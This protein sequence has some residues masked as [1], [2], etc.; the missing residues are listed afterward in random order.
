MK[1]KEMLKEFSQIM[2]LV[3]KVGEVRAYLIQ[4]PGD[5]PLDIKKSIFKDF[6]PVA[7]LAFNQAYSADFERDVWEHLF[8]PTGL[9]LV[10]NEIAIHDECGNDED[11][12]VAFRTFSVIRKDVIYL[13][14]V[15]IHPCFHKMGLYH[16]LIT[17]VTSDFDFVVTRTQSPL[18]IT[19]L[20]NVFGK[21]S[22]I[23][24]CA[25][26][27]EKEVA[28]LLADN[29]KMLDKFDGEC[30][31]GWRTYGH[32]L[33]RI[34]PKADENITS[35]LYSMIDVEAGDCVIAVCRTR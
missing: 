12:G 24:K 35:M 20:N 21:I 1:T 26:D 32:S 13:A 2:L 18:V 17:C 6:Y 29:L 4:N 8:S 25:D 5:L 3:T 15:A 10:F 14:G 34:P 19:T 30:L 7:M 27:E 23:T 22:P 11:M 33:Y 31:I 16:S 28:M 9:V